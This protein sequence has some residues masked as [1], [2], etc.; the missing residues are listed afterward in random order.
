ML[1]AHKETRKTMC[2]ELLVLYEN[3]GYNFLARTE[4]VDET[5]LHHLNKIRECNQWSDIMQIHLITL[6]WHT[7]NITSSIKL[8]IPSQNEVFMTV[9]PS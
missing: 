2:G 1:N 5:S 6:I 8:W 3:G 4:T 7:M 9:T